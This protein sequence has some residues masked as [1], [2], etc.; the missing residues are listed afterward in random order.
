MRRRNLTILAALIAAVFLTGCSTAGAIAHRWVAR[1][2][3]LAHVVVKDV[4]G[5]VVKDVTED[6]ADRLRQ[7]M[8]GAMTAT[9]AVATGS[10]AIVLSPTEQLFTMNVPGQPLA[11]YVCDSEVEPFCPFAP[12]SNVKIIKAEV[13]VQDVLA[14]GRQYGCWHRVIKAKLKG[15]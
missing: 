3:P 15:D 13:I 14:D 8:G 7:S 6:A 5:V 9:E 11:L 12:S 4:I 2:Y 1:N 10:G